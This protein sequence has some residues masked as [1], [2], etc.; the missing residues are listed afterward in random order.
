M[1]YNR[2]SIVK[3]VVAV[4]LIGAV[5]F[6]GG[7]VGARFGGDSTTSLFRDT[8]D[9]VRVEPTARN[10]SFNDDETSTVARTFQEQFRRVSAATLPVVV[11]I[12]VVNRVTRQV[13]QNPFEF[14]FGHPN[15]EPEEREFE[16]RGMGSGVIVGR[17]GDT[18]YVLTNNHVAGEA[19]EIEVGLHD[20]RSFSAELV[21]SD[22]LIDLAMLS[23]TTEEEVPI[24]TLGD[25]DSLRPGDWVFAVGNPLGFQ[26]SI[27]AG[28]VS[29][30]SRNANIQSGMSGVTDYIQTD[31]AINRGNS[32]GAL[33][34]LDGDVVGINTWIASTSG[35]NIGL[36]FAI[37][38]NN[39][40]RAI[41]DFIRE[42]EVTYSW[43]GVQV[44]TLDEEF[45]EEFLGDNSRYRGNG[46]FVSALYGDSPAA[47]SGLQPGDLIVSI[48]SEEIED[49]NDLVRTVATLEPGSRVPFGIVRDGEE[50]TVTVRTG[51]RND[52]SLAGADLWPGVSVAPL[53]ERVREQL[54]I[55]ERVDGALV[56]GVAQE[57]KAQQSG[58]RRGDIIV[59]V[60]GASVETVADFYEV[61]RGVDEEEVQFRIIRDGQQLI[62]GFVRPA[63]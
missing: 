3:T 1:K 61:L 14:F 63:A 44:S 34:N 22:D 52:N 7:I 16:S 13:P 24:A 6:A 2:I 30:T 49:S 12:N 45:A 46:A 17:D 53:S 37:P 5:G 42:G 48:D 29:A 50:I 25:S 28:I 55:E 23:F 11:E 35:G 51:R 57:S 62:L 38:V 18:V 8:S 40:R 41:E 43:L 36:G 60:N 31:A 58:L 19:D 10:V 54:E 27:T 20:G 47:R 33:V 26:S 9:I 32:G 39:A 56:T 59:A 15:S 4:A 21:G